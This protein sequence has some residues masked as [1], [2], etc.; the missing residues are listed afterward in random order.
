M[1][2]EGSIKQQLVIS[3]VG[4]QG[5]RFAMTEGLECVA[6]QALV[7]K[8]AAAAKALS[9]FFEAWDPA[10][11]EKDIAETDFMSSGEFF[12]GLAVVL[13]WTWDLL[14]EKARANLRAIVERRAR[15]N[16]DGFVGKKSWEASIEANEQR[17]R[18]D[19]VR[20]CE[21]MSE[22]HRS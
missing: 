6:L 7:E 13:D 11:L 21:S 2:D 12:E 17:C 14:T 15:H 3:G 18:D 20:C 1:L 4:G 9:D 19:G 8:D 16:Y 10:P 5:V 22:C